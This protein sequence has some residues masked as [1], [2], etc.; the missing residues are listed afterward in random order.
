MIGG[1]ARN[2]PAALRTARSAMGTPRP[3]SYIPRMDYDRLWTELA[4]LRDTMNA[5][6]ARA[7]RYFELQQAQH[8]EL[9]GEVEELRDLLLALTA[10]VDRLEARVAGLE[11]ELRAFR[12]WTSRELMDIRRELR[13]LREAAEERDELRREVDALDVRVTRLEQ[14]RDGGS[15]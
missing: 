15:T 3:D 9:R 1:A 5:G 10:R 13:L 6:F 11:S 2:E 8:V 14:R 7:D 12:D 4:G